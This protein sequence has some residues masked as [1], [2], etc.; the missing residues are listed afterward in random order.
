MFKPLFDTAQDSAPALARITLGGVLIAHGA[1]K[2]LGW[3][4]GYGYSATMDYFVTQAGLPAAV[5]FAVILVESFGSLA[6]LLGLGGRFAAAGVLALMGGAV[7]KGGHWDVGFFMNWF[8]NQRG[9]G[10]EFHLLAMGL[11][12]IVLVK[13]SGAFSLDR[14]LVRSG[15]KIR[16]R[17]QPAES[18]IPYLS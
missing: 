3:F 17:T 10:F 4:G 2:L 18:L 12:A 11:A 7:V 1:Q 5:A 13:G 8:G 9:E 15:A 16:E 14:I 6:L